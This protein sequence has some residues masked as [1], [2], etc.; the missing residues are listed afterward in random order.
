MSK[1]DMAEVFKAC[2]APVAPE[3]TNM[4]TAYWNRKVPRP[5]YRTLQKDIEQLGYC[6]TGRKYGVSD[7]AIRKWV[8]TY[9]NKALTSRQG[10]SAPEKKVSHRVSHSIKKEIGAF[11]PT[12]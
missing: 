11:W 4:H 3:Y 8:A 9:E 6:A 2:D 1:L 12:P 7:N 10:S 5:S